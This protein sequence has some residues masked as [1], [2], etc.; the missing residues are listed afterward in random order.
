M[1]GVHLFVIPAWFATS[2]YLFV[3]LAALWKGGW[4]ERTLAWL[5]LLLLAVE[6]AACP[7][8]ACAPL[9][10][11]PQMVVDSLMLAACFV[12]L[13]RAERYWVVWASSFGLLALISDLTAFLPHVSQWA[14]HSAT[15]IWSY[16]LAATILWGIGQNARA[17]R[18]GTEALKMA[19]D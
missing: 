2:L 8:T 10:P 9:F 1:L 19:A 12:C 4:R 13:V 14:W 5:E 15:L 17:T 18:P 3:A 16:L 6:R 7:G 11:A